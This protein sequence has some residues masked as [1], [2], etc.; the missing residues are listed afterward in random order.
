[1]KEAD[2]PILIFAK[3]PIT[4]EVKSRLIPYL[5]T[6]GATAL[7]ERMVSHALSIAVRSRVGPVELWCTPSTEHPFFLQC[8]KKFRAKLHRQIEG[9]LGD[10][11]AYALGRTLET[12]PMALLIGTDCPSLTSADLITAK[13]VLERGVTAVVSP[14]EDGGYVLI[15]LRQYDSA[16]FEGIHWGTGSVLEETRQ[17]LRGLGW[18]WRELPE[19]W[20]V[21]RPEDV[22]RLRDSGFIGDF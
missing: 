5:G 19:R 20:D 11:M 9:T 21:D 12:S 4:G 13:E 15:G 7:Y 18:S 17:R 1:M 2:C 8:E 6:E 22:E 16:L 14:A 10:R 3:A